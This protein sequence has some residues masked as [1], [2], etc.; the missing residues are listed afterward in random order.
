M[1]QIVSLAI[2]ARHGAS[3]YKQL[4]F[5]CGIDYVLTS[6]YHASLLFCSSSF[7]QMSSAEP[8]VSVCI[9]CHNAGMFISSCIDSLLLQSWSNIEIVI[10]DDSSVDQSWDIISEYAARNEN[11]KAL[12]AECMCAAVARN[13]AFSASSGSFIKFLDADDLLHPCAIKNQ[14]MKLINAKKSIICGDWGRF[15]RSDL[16]DFAYNPT[17]I[18][19]DLDPTEWLVRDWSDGQPMTQ[20]GMFLLPREL[21]EEA[22]GWDET[23]RNNPNDDF[24]F[25]VRVFLCADK[26]LYAENSTLYYR[27]GLPN[28]LSRRRSEQALFSTY[29]SISEGTSTLLR[30][31]SDA[32]ASSACAN[33]FQ[34]FI[35]AT[36]PQCPELI[37]LAE[38]K[39]RNLGGSNLNFPSG[40]RLA[41][42]ASLIGWQRA[43]A[44]KIVLLELQSFIPAFFL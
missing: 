6:I 16:T 44:L 43:K 3:P 12:R 18:K 9:P 42:L 41:F 14:A 22:G 20:P 29:Q 15:Y 31:R 5:L 1:L 35:Y 30:Y 37:S 25:F 34:N 38:N 27:S 23:L 33:L 11:I 7:W 10:V 13:I 21:V 28:S 8:L 19:D 2:F 26:I 40:P 39:V 24:I 32:L 4:M 36:F 17:T